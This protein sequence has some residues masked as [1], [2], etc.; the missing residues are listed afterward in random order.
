M[1]MRLAAWGIAALCALPLFGQTYIKATVA[2]AGNFGYSSAISGNTLVVGAPLESSGASGV[3]GN[4]N[5]SSAPQAGAAYVYVWDGVSWT[6]QAYLKP[7]VTHANLHFGSSVGI[8]G[9]TIVVGAPFESSNAT[10]VNGDQTNTSLNKAGAAYVFVRNGTQWTQQAYLKA[11]VARLSSNGLTGY[12]FGNSVA[13]DGDTVVVGANEENSAATGVNGDP[14]LT[15]PT[16][17]GAAYVFTRTAGAWSQQAYLKSYSPTKDLFFG[18]TVAVNGDLVAVGGEDQTNS[19]GI[20]PPPGSTGGVYNQGEVTV[21]SRSGTTWTKEAFIKAPVLHAGAQ[22]GGGGLALQGSR[23]AVG[24]PFESSDANGVDVG[25]FGPYREAG[26]L[27]TFTRSA[28]AWAQEAYVKPAYVAPGAVFGWSA[29]LDTNNLLVGSLFESSASAGINGNPADTSLGNS[30]AAYLFTLSG[31]SWTQQEYIKAP[32]PSASAY[33]GMSVARQNGIMAVGAYNEASNATGIGGSDTD[34]SMPGA[35]AVFAYTPAATQTVTVQSIPAGITF[36]TSGAGCAPGAGYVTPQP[37]TWQIG[38]SCTITMPSTVP[39]A[40]SQSV[41][42]QWEDASTNPVRNLNAPAVS[43]AYTTTYKTQYPLSIGLNP[44]VGGTVSGAALFSYFDAG[45]ALILTAHPAA[46]YVFT[47]WS[48]ACAGTGTCALTING[49]TVVTA[50]FQAS[51]LPLTINVPATVQYTVGG[52]TYTGTQTIMLPPGAY[53]LAVASPQSSGVGTQLVFTSWSDAGAASHTVNLVNTPVSVT[54]SFS[55]QYLLT[56]AASPAAGGLV[57]GAGFYNPGTQ[58]QVLAGANAGYTFGNWSGGCSGSV[59]CVVT[60]NAPATVTANFNAL[61]FNLSI[62]VPVGVAYTLSGLPLTGPSTLQLPAGTYSLALASP[63]AAGKGTQRVF[64][65]WSDGGAQ[66]HDINLSAPLTVTGTFK[67]QYL[68]T[69]TVTPAGQGT[70]TGGPWVDAGTNAFI[71][72]LGNP[73]YEFEYWSGGACTGSV[74]VCVLPMNAPASVTGHFS[75]PL[76]E[77]SYPF[78]DSATPSP[79]VASAMAYDAGQHQVILFGGIGNGVFL[80]DTWIFVGTSWEKVLPSGSIPP[81]RNLHAMAY[82]AGT[83]KVVMV[84]GSLGID[85]LGNPINENDTYTFDASVDLWEK[86]AHLPLP[87]MGAQLVEYGSNVLMFGGIYGTGLT[88]GIVTDGIVRS[89]TQM[90]NGTAWVDLNPAHHPPGRFGGAIA[91]DSVRQQVVLVGGY[92]PGAGGL[93]TLLDTWIFDG[94]DW[95]QASPATNLPSLPSAMTFDPSIQQTVAFTNPQVWTWDGATWIPRETT[96]ALPSMAV[97]DNFRQQVLAVV[98]NFV[99]LYNSW[100]RV[101]PKV[102]LVPGGTPTVTI[103]PVSGN[104]YVTFTLKQQGN[105]PLEVLATPAT[106]N[107]LTANLVGVEVQALFPGTPVAWTEVWPRSIGPGFKVMTVTG[108]YWEPSTALS[109]HWSISALV[110]LP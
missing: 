59:S 46:N 94:N 3:N 80:S 6:L 39:G 56:T 1:R 50:S 58:V 23:L 5:D 64:V 19:V 75:V 49:A 85:N 74:G 96:P 55:P 2:Q 82:H 95:H 53:T 17:A 27:Y 21:F 15:T 26:A 34:T 66:S 8:G 86:P 81:G 92:T 87:R 9:D 16:Y 14:T 25:V 60:M 79:R 104:Y 33:F 98:P 29:A 100:V 76:G 88:N 91:Y 97:Y 71:S 62:N 107:G 28:G 72:A 37:L 36:S 106:I 110:N 83:G 42:V 78:A 20:N 54:G 109:G 22:F 40:G 35:G 52:Q 108:D 38:A 57:T 84:G 93:Q 41:F 45:T 13:V 73:G 77:Y 43:T 24:A 89:D 32:H 18:Q 12:L 63:Q 4:P 105:V 69:T 7:A 44:A 67:T 102:S 10:G 99:G 103:D 65:S 101:A 61:K 31:R 90:W 30:G 11:S 51:Q 47:G 48:G 70:I 68:L